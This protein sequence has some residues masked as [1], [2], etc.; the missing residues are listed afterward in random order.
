MTLF[1]L[2]T[3]LGGLSL[4]LFGMNIMG[5]ALERSAGNRLQQML[6]RMTARKAAGL[7]TGIAITAVIQ[8]SSAT[9]VMVVGF[10][11]SGLMTLRQSIHV[12][13]GANIGTTVT[14]WIL[15]LGGISGDNLLLQLL[16]PT[17][18]TPI[19]ALLGIILYLFVKNK[20]RQ[21]AGLIL[22]G[23]ATL[24]FGMSAMTDAVSGLAEKP[25]FRDLFLLF[26]NPLLGLL[27]G[28]LLTAIIQSSSASVGI[29]QAL[30]VTGSITYGAAIPI[31]MGQNVGTCVTALLSSIGANKNARRAAFVHLSFNLLGSFVWLSIYAILDALLA[32]ALFDQTATLPG[33]AAAH[34]VFNLLCTLLLL[35]AA[36]LLERLVCRLIPDGK[37]PDATTELDERLLAT[38]TIALEHCR[39]C[40]VHMMETAVAALGESTSCLDRFD[41]S[42]AASVHRREEETDRAE[43]TLSSYLLKLST[44]RMDEQD[45]ALATVLLKVVG[46]F[47]RIADHAVDIVEAAAELEQKKRSFSEQARQELDRLCLA[48]DEIL[49]LTLTAFAE[50]DTRAAGQV[51][52]LEQV[53]DR[54]REQMRTSHMLRLQRQ[55]CSMETGFIW[56]DLLTALSRTSDHCSNVA[57]CV[58]DLSKDHL[59]LHRS[60]RI[61]KQD[62]AAFREHY[63]RF[64]EKYL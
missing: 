32:P 6:E 17:S 40:A 49:S 21:D 4:F 26:R 55:D 50:N 35:P 13:M 44:H 59:T 48:V 43:D 1:D 3:M 56:S 7:L 23:F 57:G 63:R 34:T 47:E 25:A 60:L 37:A 14:A 41:K 36:S 9:T 15:S 39:D 28:A 62:S 61:T 12:I 46:D 16:K 30:A 18:F 19:L 10:V 29:L 20:K 11:N 33:I 51:E 27:A 8:S 38:P 24:M 42:L 2:L 52:P 53:I 5:Q 54:M 22:L 58:I 31:I 64:S 45:S